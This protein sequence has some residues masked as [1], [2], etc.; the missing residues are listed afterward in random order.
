[1]GGEIAKKVHADPVLIVLCGRKLGENPT[2][3][4]KHDL[5]FGHHTAVDIEYC[6]TFEILGFNLWKATVTDPKRKPD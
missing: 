4:C 3:I 6:T 1:V 2:C 5:E